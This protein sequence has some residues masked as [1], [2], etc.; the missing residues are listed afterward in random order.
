M[1]RIISGIYRGRRLQTPPGRDTRPTSDRVRTALF[2]ILGAWLAQKTVLDLYA[3][4]GGIGF[5]CLSRGARQ[6]TF[7]EQHAGAAQVL[8]DN[9]A[10][11]QV[12]DRVRLLA[13]SFVRAVP[14]LAGQSFDFIYADPPYRT[15]D[16][17]KLLA[18]LASAQVAHAE[19]VLVVEHAR[20]AGVDADA[21]VHGWHAY[22][23]ASYGITSLT[24]FSPTKVSA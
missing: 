21:V 12:S 13:G 17:P 24:F 23:C 4:A 6:V 11:L 2:N 5:E 19:T 16:L 10:M 18:L 3:G 15:A 9:A 14:L 1:V 7:V 20:S 22:R 8:R